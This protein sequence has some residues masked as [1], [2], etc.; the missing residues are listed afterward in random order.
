MHARIAQF[1]SHPC[2]DNVYYLYTYVLVKFEMVPLTYFANQK[3]TN[4]PEPNGALSSEVP[5]S[6][7]VSANSKVQKIASSSKRVWFH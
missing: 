7:V 5:S 1:T 4:L 3:K 6:A 2:V